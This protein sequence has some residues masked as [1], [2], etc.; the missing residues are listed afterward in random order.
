MIVDLSK[1]NDA[2]IK[3]LSE[4]LDR[5]KCTI[6]STIAQEDDYD[7]WLHDR[8]NGIGGSD[9]AAICGVSDWSSP[10]DI[11]LSKTQPLGDDHQSEAARWGNVLEQTIAAEW[12][13]RNNRE[14]VEIG[15]ASCRERV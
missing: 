13:H 2:Q 10:R 5:N 3:A 7:G 6:N 12:A 4:I 14:Y 11:Y 9:I 1:Y 8:R 15:R